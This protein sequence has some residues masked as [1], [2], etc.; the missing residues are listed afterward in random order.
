MCCVRHNK[1]VY[2]LIYCKGGEELELLAH[3]ICVSSVSGVINHVII[4]HWYLFML[5]FYYD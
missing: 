3:Y 5:Y 1:C 4:L 2:Q